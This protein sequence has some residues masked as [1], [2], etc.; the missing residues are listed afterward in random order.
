MIRLKI[1]D[2]VE[3]AAQVRLKFG[4]VD[5]EFKSRLEPVFRIFVFHKITQVHLIGKMLFRKRAFGT[6]LLIYVTLATL[7]N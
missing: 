2:P 3:E 6:L 5:C 7:G 1:L 4:H